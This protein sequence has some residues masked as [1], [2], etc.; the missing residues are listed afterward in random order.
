MGLH[1]F[2]S[3]VISLRVWKNI[4][5]K[6][7]LNFNQVQLRDYCNF[8]VPVSVRYNNRNVYGVVS[9]FDGRYSVCNLYRLTRDGLPVKYFVNF[10]CDFSDVED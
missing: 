9:Y 6:F 1:N 2:M 10:E 3:E 4:L 8:C 7:Y 5:K